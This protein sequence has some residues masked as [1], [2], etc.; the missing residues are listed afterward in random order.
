MHEIEQKAVILAG[1]LNRGE[2]QQAANFIRNEIYHDPGEALAIIQTA[3]QMEAP[4]GVDDILGS[5]SGDLTI[6]NKYTGQAEAWAGRLPTAA[7]PQQ[8]YGSP[9]T[10]QPQ[11]GSGAEV[12]GEVVTGVLTGILAAG[13]VSAAMGAGRHS[14]PCY[15]PRYEPRYQPHYQPHRR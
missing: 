3:R 10:V 6:V 5:P 13:L 12:A 14:E 1:E 9:Q 7:Q 15:Q 8:E 11:N 4:R 2:S